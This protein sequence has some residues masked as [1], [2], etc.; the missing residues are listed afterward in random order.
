MPDDGW[1]EDADTEYQE[2]E[3]DTWGDPVTEDTGVFQE[4]YGEMDTYGEDEATDYYNDWT[5]VEVYE[6]AGDQF[7][8][9][10]DYYEHEFWE[11]PEKYEAA[12][13]D[14][15][16]NW[17]K[18]LNRDWSETDTESFLAYMQDEEDEGVMSFLKGL[19]SNKGLMDI[20]AKAGLG[21]LAALKSDRAKPTVRRSSGGGGG[22]PEAVSALGG[23]MGGV[24]KRSEV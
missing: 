13:Q 9:P 19:A 7:I 23:V 10:E 5:Q 24:K 6:D 2:I 4:T 12:F 8:L 14:E 3:S 18:A 1:F 21:A 20:L 15:D 22:Q 17:E 11:D 16:W